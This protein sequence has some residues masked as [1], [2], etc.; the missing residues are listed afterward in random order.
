[1]HITHVYFRCDLLLFSGEFDIP[2][3]D[4]SI[5]D[6]KW[7]PGD[8]GSGVVTLELTLPPIASHLQGKYDTWTLH[9]RSVRKSATC[10]M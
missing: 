10:R 5:V 2:S 3:Q 9:F 4:M 1:M 8:L 6:A 7:T